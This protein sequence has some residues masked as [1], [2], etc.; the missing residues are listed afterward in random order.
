MTDTGCPHPDAEVVVLDPDQTYAP[1]QCRWCSMC[2]SLYEPSDDASTGH[3]SAPS[4]AVL[5]GWTCAACLVFNGCVKELLTECR[6]CG[7]PRRKT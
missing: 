2:G 5:P 6:S 7:A 3:W 1:A 4:G